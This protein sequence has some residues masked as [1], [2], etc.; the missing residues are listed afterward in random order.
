MKVSFVNYIR[1][2]KEIGHLTLKAIENAL[3]K[4]DLILRKDVD[5]FERDFAKYIGCRYGI[6]V[7][8]CTD[9]LIIGLKAVG[10]GPGDE[11]ITVSHTFWASIEAI[12]HCGA[13]PVLVDVGEDYLMSHI[14]LEKAITPRTKAIIP[15]H[16]NGRVCNM[17]EIMSIARKNN[18]FVVEDAA[19]AIGATYKGRKAGSFGDVGCFSFYPSKILGAYGDAGMIVTNDL[20]IKRQAWLF[21]SHGQ[22]IKTKDYPILDAGWS[23]RLQNIQAAVL[24][25]KLKYLDGWIE[26]RRNL[27]KKYNEAFSKINQITIPPESNEI[28]NDSYQ[29]YVIRADRRDELAEFLRENGIEILIKD[30]VANHKQPAWTYRYGNIRLPLSEQLADEVI[31]L[32][33][34]PHVTEEE[35]DYVISKVKEF[36][37][38]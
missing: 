36:Y 17:D 2:F 20:Y 13:T 3:S 12:I 24:N 27:A 34:H 23:S 14:E 31:S 35:S 16:F 11:V 22:G 7:N 18:L 9:A 15:V 26:K 33:M 5:D 25:V 30:E 38:K 8:S 21:R 1:E 4:G 10:V 37:E 32:P 28:N 29:N 19:Q 6:G